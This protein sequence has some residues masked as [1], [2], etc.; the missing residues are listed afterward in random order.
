[1]IQIRDT[2]KK[3]VIGVFCLSL[4]S[5]CSTDEIKDN[6]NAEVESTISANGT[7]AKEM[8]ESLKKIREEE[9][10]RE[11]AIKESATTL[12]FDRLE[13]DFGNTKPE[14][15]NKTTFKVTNTGDKPLVIEDVSASCGCT[16]PK[17]PEQ[18]IPPGKSDVIEV[19]FKANP[20]QEGVQSKTVTVTANTVEKIHKLE[21][22]A[23]VK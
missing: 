1:M 7:S 16:T 3:Y 17:K 22:R 21:I 14:V 8:E 10:A 13:H 19:V 15:E 5:S 20:G 18:P 23:N 4:L 6:R 12:Q 11:R 9:E 2:M